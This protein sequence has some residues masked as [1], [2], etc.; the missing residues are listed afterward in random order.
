MQAQT[1][2]YD[3]YQQHVQDDPQYENPSGWRKLADVINWCGL[4]GRI[5]WLVLKLA[6]EVRDEPFNRK[7]Q[8]WEMKVKDL[9]MLHLLSR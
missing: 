1:A 9:R 2:S 7:L 5:R 6:R 4:D 8:D 3:Q